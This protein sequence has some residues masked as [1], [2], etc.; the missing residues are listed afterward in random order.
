MTTTR[1]TTTRIVAA[2]AASTLALATS[3]C[4]T[5][6]GHRGGHGS[7]MGAAT[8]SSS[9]AADHNQADLMFSMMMV[10]HHL[11]AIEMSDLV[12]DRTGSAGLRDLAERI[13]GAQ[14]PEVDRM[15]GWL[16]EWGTAPMTG[17]MDGH[18]MGGMGGMMSAEDLR[19]L[20]ALRGAAFDLTWLEMMVEH[21]EGAVVM[22]RDVLRQGRHAGTRE[23]AEQIIVA[24]QAEIAEM[25]AM[26]AG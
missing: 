26:L 18:A 2:A 21:H 16:E 12:P 15:T 10:P 14:Q 9:T 23:L 1:R 3:A 13:R 5:D 11:Q 24:Q 7:M 17:S 25:R 19:D 6:D 20:A 4:S 8:P 22:A